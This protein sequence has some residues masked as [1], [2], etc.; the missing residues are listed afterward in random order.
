MKKVITLSVLLLSITA[1]SV[2][3]AETRANEDG[4]GNM[5]YLDRHRLDCGTKAIRSFKL[6]RPTR[7]TIAY[8]YACGSRSMGAGSSKET[9]ANEDGKGNMIYLDRHSVSCGNHALQSFRLFR[10]TRTTIAYSY[11]CGTVKLKK[12][13]HHETRATDYGKGNMIYLDRQNVSCGSRYMTGFKLFR[14][15][16]TTVAYKYS[17][18]S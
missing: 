18:G 16:P 8:S 17:C 1:S 11:K 5:I 13:T 9:R 6:F 2:F 12:I 4:K 14:P 15:T 3:A 10:P 7:D